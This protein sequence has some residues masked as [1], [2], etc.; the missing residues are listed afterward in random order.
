[1]WPGCLD[2]FINSIPKGRANLVPV[3]QNGLGLDL[4]LMPHQCEEIETHHA[5]LYLKVQSKKFGEKLWSWSE[6]FA[7]LIKICINSW[8]CFV[9]VIIIVI[10]NGNV[11]IKM[12][13]G[14]S[15]LIKK[16]GY[17]ILFCE[18]NQLDS[19]FTSNL[20]PKL[21]MIHNSTTC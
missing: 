13:L 14:R 21:Q 7:L 12:K 8:S 19:S 15:S 3:D 6:S 16:S 1:M 4:N 5:H 18:W 11:M 17:K 10:Y 9:I 20:S 2:P